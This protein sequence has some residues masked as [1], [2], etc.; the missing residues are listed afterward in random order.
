[1]TLVLLCV[2][3]VYCRKDN[4]DFLEEL[5]LDVKHFSFCLYKITENFNP[6]SSFSRVEL[7]MTP[8]KSTAGA[9]LGIRAAEL[10]RLDQLEITDENKNFMNFICTCDHVSWPPKVKQKLESTT[11]IEISRKL[12]VP[13]TEMNEVILDSTYHSYLK[14]LVS[15]PP[16]H[17]EISDSRLTSN[18]IGCGSFDTWHGSPDARVRGTEIICH[19]FTDDESSGSDT[20]E[21]ISETASNAS[22]ISNVSSGTTTAIEAKLE[23]IT[24]HLP[25]LVSTCVVSSFIENNLHKTLDPM[26]PCI[27]IDPYRF[28][29]CFYDCTD[30]LLLI[31]EPKQLQSMNNNTLS[32][33][34]ALLLWLT[35]NHR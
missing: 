10:Y 20:Y 27:L 31:S 25:Q 15:Q 13:L 33:S 9:H 3:D 19:K 14:N 21:E 34:A 18:Y 4:E 32:R 24:R 6:T 29:V 28:T 22:N 17:V 8:F 2:C 30:D 11:F 7:N 23:S 35:I 26:V 5:L 1:V 16:S 12:L